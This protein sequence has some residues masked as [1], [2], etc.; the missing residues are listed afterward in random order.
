MGSKRTIPLPQSQASTPPTH[1]R[2]LYWLLV[3][4]KA[5][6]YRGSVPGKSVIGDPFRPDPPA[7]QSNGATPSPWIPSR[8]IPHA[9]FLCF[10]NHLR[11]S[12][13][14][15]RPRS[16]HWTLGR[17]H[18]IQPALGGGG[19][20]SFNPRQLLA[21]QPTIQLQGAETEN[22]PCSDPWEGHP[23]AAATAGPTT[24]ASIRRFKNCAYYAFGR[25]G[26]TFPRTPIFEASGPGAHC[27]SLPSGPAAFPPTLPLPKPRNQ[28]EVLPPLAHQLLAK[29]VFST[30][31]PG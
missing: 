23:A 21:S 22:Q 10:Q 5:K 24:P 7:A 3:A 1:S 11:R 17:T 8:L 20:G 25:G 9:W 27:S 12:G 15:L 13:H 26:S 30:Q 18:L 14:G 19:F 29:I 6:L 31:P 4:S 28:L 16:P 2:R